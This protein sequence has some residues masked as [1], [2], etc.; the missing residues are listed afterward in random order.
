MEERNN[1]SQ[2]LEFAH[3]TID[4]LTQQTRHAISLAFTARRIVSE[5]IGASQPQMTGRKQSTFELSTPGS[6]KPPGAGQWIGG[7]WLEPSVDVL[8]LAAKAWSEGSAQTALIL[9]GRVLQQQHLSVSEEAHAHLLTSAILRAS[10]NT[11]KASEHA[12]HALVT[13]RNT[14]CNYMLTSKA[15]FYRGL[16]WL[17]QKRYA[18]ARWCFALAS[19]LPGYEDQVEVNLVDAS[20]HCRMLESTG[21]GRK[22]DLTSI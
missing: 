22:I 7:S 1:L 14:G 17:S 2:R 20:E 12:E 11:A 16:C 19:R 18:Q 4:E 5:D 3:R 9:V 6:Q 21:E 15:E 13:A 10:G 8:A